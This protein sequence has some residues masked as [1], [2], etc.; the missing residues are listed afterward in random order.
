MPSNVHGQP[1]EKTVCLD[2]LVAVPA[3]MNQNLVK[4][5]KVLKYWNFSHCF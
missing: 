5:K 2:V 1:V 3:E 4:M